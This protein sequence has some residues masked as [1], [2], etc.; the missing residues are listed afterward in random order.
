MAISNAPYVPPPTKKAPDLKKDFYKARRPEF[1][2]D[3]G[4][5]TVSRKQI[6]ELKAAPPPPPQAKKKAPVLTNNMEPKGMSK[7]PTRA[8]TTATP[9][10]PVLP[11]AP[12]V[13]PAE[14]I[15]F[16]EA[17]LAQ[18]KGIAKDRFLRATRPEPS[19]KP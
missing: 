15:K 5:G 2:P 9:T 7:V 11:K 10:K 1:P 16:M 17:R 3:A 18:H 19:R 6:N 14:R 8:T 12:P 13:P 4:Q